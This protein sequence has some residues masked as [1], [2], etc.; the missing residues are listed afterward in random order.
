MVRKRKEHTQT[1]AGQ[2]SFGKEQQS[3]P[4]E[5]RQHRMVTF[6]VVFVVGLFFS[7]AF[8]ATITIIYFI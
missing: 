4:K 5:R 6:S 3:N 1:D 2:N 7:I 8:M